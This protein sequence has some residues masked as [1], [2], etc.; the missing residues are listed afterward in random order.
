MTASDVEQAARGWRIWPRR[1]SVSPETRLPALAQYHSLKRHTVRRIFGFIALMLFCFVY[2]FFFS[3]LVPYYF[4]FLA[5]PVILAM[6]LAIWALPDVNW[7]PTKQLSWFFYAFF[8]VL[9]CWP[10]YLAIALPGLPW[11]TLIRLTSF[12]MALLLLICCSISPQFRADLTR[13]WRAV[14]AIPTLLCIFILIQLVSIGESRNISVSIQKFIVAQTTWT[15]AFFVGAYLFLR[16]GQIK[17][18]A[19]VLWAM[20]IFV[21]IIAIWE[22]RI[23][24]LPWAGHIPSFLKIDDEA[25]QEILTAHMRAYT[26]RYR[27]EATFS[28]P[29]GLAEYLALTLPFVLHFCTPRWPMKLRLAACTSVPLILYADYLSGSKLGMIGALA[30]SSVYCLMAAF[31]HWR[32]NKSSLIAAATFFFY[33]AVIGVVGLMMAAS[34]SFYITIMGDASHTAS[35]QARIEQIH[36]GMA[37]LLQWPFGYGIGQAA[38]T[39]SNASDYVTIDSY[40]LSVAIEY[41]ILGFIAYYGIFAIAIC[42]GSRRYLID[43]TANE[44]QSFLL[45]ITASFI[46]FMVAKSVFSQQDNHPVVFMMLGALLGLI[47]ARR[48]LVQSHRVPDRHNIAV[49]NIGRR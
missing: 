48:N 13:S 24:R 44:D 18:W 19:L 30:A 46:A 8:I 26:N 21:S 40:F 22:H 3:V 36:V 29:L 33:P 41:G 2:G 45:P 32:R 43:T 6:L 11:I 38:I 10:N 27:A 34:H 12:P 31:R 9:I 17:R 5:M 42:E 25:V 37:K 47:A 1:K 4:A 39:I 14:S 7:A 15:A 20:A 23:G 16:P 49:R 35:T 28:T